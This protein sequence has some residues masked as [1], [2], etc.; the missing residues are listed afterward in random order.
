MT[1]EKMELQASNPH[2]LGSIEMCEN[3]GALYFTGEKKNRSNVRLSC[4]KNGAYSLPSYSNCPQAWKNLYLGNSSNAIRF[5]KEI[6]SINSIFAIASFNTSRRVQNRQ[7][8]QG[9]GVD[10]YPLSVHGVRFFKGTIEPEHRGSPS[11]KL[12]S[13]D[14]SPNHRRLIHFW[15]MSRG[16]PV[17]TRQPTMGVVSRKRS[18]SGGRPTKPTPLNTQVGQD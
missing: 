11:W 3:C 13:S 17:H 5:R 14:C 8:Q 2:F 9:H 12:K 10:T 18:G 4:C 7:G 16:L 6:R 15:R 1:T